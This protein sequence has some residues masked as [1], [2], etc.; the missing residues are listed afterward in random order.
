MKK[1]LTAIKNLPPQMQMMLG[2]MGLST[3]IG[4][5]Y[6]LQRFLFP[7][8]PTIFIIAG[9]GVVVAVVCGISWLVAKGLSGRGRKRTRQLEADLASTAGSGLASMDV[10]AAIKDNNE[11]FFRA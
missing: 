1:I 7:H 11:K 3:P 8:T 4:A 9:I 5:I 2:L 6:L 10:R